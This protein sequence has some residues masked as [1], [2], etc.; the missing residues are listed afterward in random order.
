MPSLPALQVCFLF[1]L[2][3]HQANEQGKI[4]AIGGSSALLIDQAETSVVLVYEHGT[5]KGV[6]GGIEKKALAHDTAIKELIEEV[7]WLR[8]EQGRM[9][10]EM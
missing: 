1:P 4:Q 6:S 3:F 8:C 9:F 5:W 10:V 2:Q 7:T